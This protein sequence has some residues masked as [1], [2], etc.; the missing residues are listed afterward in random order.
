MKETSEKPNSGNQT[1]ANELYMRK[2]WISYKA[3]ER[4]SE[5]NKNETKMD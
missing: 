5:I 1:S 3:L 2:K 4:A